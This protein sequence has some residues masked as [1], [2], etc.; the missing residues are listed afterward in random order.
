ME[1]PKDVSLTRDKKRSEPNVS[2]IYSAVMAYPKRQSLNKIDAGV[3][4][5]LGLKSDKKSVSDL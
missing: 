1:K 3:Y 2:L 4:S 5:M